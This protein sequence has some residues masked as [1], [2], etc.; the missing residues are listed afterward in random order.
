MSTLCRMVVETEY[1]DLPES[2]IKC[3]KKSILDTVAVIIGG[4]AMD[5]ISAVVDLVKEKGGKPESFI[6]FYGGKVPASE[7]ALAIGPMARAMDMG[8]VHRYAGHNSEYTLPALLAVLG[9]K[10][11]V[12]GK[13]FITAFALG[14]EVLIRIGDAYRFW[15]A[16]PDSVH[17]QL[18]RLERGGVLDSKSAGRTRIYR[19]NPRYSFLKELKNLLS[20]AL[21]FYP[22]NEQDRLLVFRRRPRRKDKPL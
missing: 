2:A 10:N 22:Q 4:S 15:E 19:F 17:K 12:S 1:N 21:S 20:K 7:A 9:L 18:V 11:I 6:P 8:Q 16:D 5:G 3:A 13:E 14:Q